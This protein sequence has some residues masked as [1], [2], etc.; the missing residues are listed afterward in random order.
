MKALAASLAAL[1][2]AGGAWAQGQPTSGV[3]AGAPRFDGINAARDIRVD[4]RLDNALPLETTFRDELGNVVTLGTYFGHRPVLM[5]MPFYQCK[6]TCLAMLNGITDLLREPGL[7]FAVG[8]DF[9]VVTISIN[10][11]ETAAL[12]SAKKKEYLS[13][14]GIPGADT[15]WHFLT[16]D[17]AQIK[18]VADAAGYRYIYDPRTD[19]YAHASVIWFA[20]P[21]GHVSRYLFGVN[22]PAKDVRLALTEAGR[23]KIGSVADQVLL[24]CYHYDPQQGRY[25]L[26]VFRLL[27]VAGFAT[28]ALL[29]SFMVLSFRREAREGRSGRAGRGGGPEENVR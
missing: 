15:G 5:V 12:A 26:A 9:D 6:G 21:A 10:P 1:L 20:T 11:K 14:L 28:V 29:G 8:R 23:G 19:Q 2:L 24:F 7:R 27:Q 13:Q 4:Q 3:G 16:G 25:G 22:Y 17:E 18:R